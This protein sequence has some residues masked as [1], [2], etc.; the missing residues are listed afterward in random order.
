MQYYSTNNKDL[1]VSL[2]TA[3]IKGLADDNG[4]F[5]PETIREF[6]D[7]FFELIRTMSFQEI[8]FEVAKA[9]FWRRC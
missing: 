4:L 9:F 1:R 2:E 6:P 5:M 3:V 7:E 8:A